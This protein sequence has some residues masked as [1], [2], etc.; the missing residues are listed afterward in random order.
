MPDLTNTL[1]KGGATGFG[2][3]LVGIGI[4]FLVLFLFGGIFI[5]A[6]W[7]VISKILIF[8][9]GAWVAKT[10]IFGGR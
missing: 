4:F 1:Q 3:I 8:I 10:F 9:I 7:D 6:N 5:L 2:T